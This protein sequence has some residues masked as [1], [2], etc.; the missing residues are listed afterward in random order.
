VDLAQALTRIWNATA[1]R[2]NASAPDGI[3]ALSSNLAPIRQWIAQELAHA[4]AG[5]A[6]AAGGAPPQ[7]TAMAS[8]LAAMG[9]VAAGLQVA[10]DGY[11]DGTLGREEARAVSSL[12]ANTLLTFVASFRVA[13]QA[14][15]LATFGAPL[16]PEPEAS[17]GAGDGRPGPAS[18]A[19]N[20]TGQE[21][22]AATRKACCRYAELQG[23][24]DIQRLQ[25]TSAAI[26]MASYTVAFQAGLQRMG[27]DLAAVAGTTAPALAVLAGTDAAVLTL[28]ALGA[29]VTVPLPGEVPPAWVPGP[30]AE[31]DPAVRDDSTRTLASRCD[32]VRCDLPVTEARMGIARQNLAASVLT[33]VAYSIYAAS[34]E[35]G[36]AVDAAPAPQALIPAPDPDR[37]M[38]WAAPLLGHL[39]AQVQ[40]AL[41]PPGL[42]S[43]LGAVPGPSAAEAAAFAGI[44]PGADGSG[45]LPEVLHVLAQNIQDQYWPALAELAPGALPPASSLA[46]ML[47]GLYRLAAAGLERRG[48][49][50]AEGSLPERPAD[51]QF[52]ANLTTLTQYAV[53]ASDGLRAGRLDRPAALAVLGALTDA[54]GTLFLGWAIETSAVTVEI[55]TLYQQGI[56]GPLTRAR[57]EILG[58]EPPP[59]APMRRCQAGCETSR[60]AL[61]ETADGLAIQTTQ[62]NLAAYIEAVVGYLTNE[63]LAI[64]GV[65][66]GVAA[67]LDPTTAPSRSPGRRLLQAEHREVPGQPGPALA[68][69]YRDGATRTP[70]P[71]PTPVPS[72]D[73]ACPPGAC[74]LS[75]SRQL[76]AMAQQT[77]N[78][79]GLTLTAYT[80]NLMLTGLRIALAAEADP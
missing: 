6:T 14:Q 35:L 39:Q 4:T 75:F 61:Q 74:D 23:A 48:P 65:A 20:G 32:A 10:A 21:P 79:A 67:S 56:L 69:L 33:L 78:A 3:A 38:V 11:R 49:A 8:Q 12:A 36:L 5:E 45:V 37:P 1:G 28:A 41:R 29:G 64:T 71:G 60:K 73:R 66:R 59:G 68:A 27:A 40:E 16:V 42:A 17:L 58:L 2:R 15:F 76:V 44:T 43:L 34:V 80:L 77:R 63:V 54:I 52:Y 18:P 47:S 55:A 26:S 46:G 72:P 19:G 57:A 53:A 50:G 31:A 13:I 22:A 62:T 51:W 25:G 9:G 70:S 7:P 30:G 24:A